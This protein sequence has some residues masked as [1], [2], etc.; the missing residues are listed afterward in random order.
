MLR[1]VLFCNRRGVV[2]VAISITRCWITSTTP[3]WN[4]EHFTVV[5][6]FFICLSLSLLYWS[7]SLSSLSLSRL[8]TVSFSSLCVCALF[9]LQCISFIMKYD[10]YDRFKFLAVD[11]FFLFILKFIFFSL[12]ALSLDSKWLKLTSQHHLYVLVC[13]LMKFS[14]FFF[15]F[16]GIARAHTEHNFK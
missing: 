9:C 8:A 3:T 12:L 5:F 15:I 14:W 13:E 16:G 10:R 11:F 6:S 4:N 7:L 1:D 2:G